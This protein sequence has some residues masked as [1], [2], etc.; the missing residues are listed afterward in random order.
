MPPRRGQLLTLI[1]LFLSRVR[2]RMED[3]ARHAGAAEHP[4]A[5]QYLN[6]Y[7]WMRVGLCNDLAV[8]R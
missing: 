3:R 5:F 6:W 7:N 1:V 8:R 2:I 4:M